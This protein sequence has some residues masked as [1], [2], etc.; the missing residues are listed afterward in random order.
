R[1][2]DVIGLAEMAMAEDDGHIQGTLE[3]DL[4]ALTTD[5]EKQEVDLLFANPYADNPALVSI[6]AGA[7]GTDAQDW[8]EMLLRMYLRWAEQTGYDAQV[9]EAIAGDEAGAKSATIEIRGPNA[10]GWLSSEHGVQRL[11]RLSPFDAAHR[12]HTSFA[13]VDVI[14]DL[15]DEVEVEIDPDELR[16]ETVRAGGRGG[17][18]VRAT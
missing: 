10:Y 17:P 4:R 7:G 18:R 9:R 13:S 8:A 2:K 15:G 1:A 3:Q 11:V 12:R 6:H 16:I 5:V 14:P